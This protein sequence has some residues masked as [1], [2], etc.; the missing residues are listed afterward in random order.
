MDVFI[1]QGALLCEECGISQQEEIQ[2]RVG[3]DWKNQLRVS[4]DV[5]PQGPYCDGG[6]EADSPQHCDHCGVFLENPLTTDGR[7]YVEEAL[8]ERDPTE[9]CLA[10]TVW[11]PFYGVEKEG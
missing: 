9:R 8:L 7:R 1:Y 3:P 11:A 5:Y 6:G 4:P 10:V 2:E